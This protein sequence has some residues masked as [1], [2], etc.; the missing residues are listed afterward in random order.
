[1]IIWK[2][3]M[4]TLATTMFVASAGMAI[5]VSPTEN[6]FNYRDTLNNEI[7]PSCNTPVF[8][9]YPNERIDST[10][11]VTLIEK[12]GILPLTK[13]LSVEINIVNPLEKQYNK[14]KDFK[15]YQNLINKMKV[16]TNLKVIGIGN[17]ATFVNDV[18]ANNAY[19]V[20]GIFTYGGK[21]SS[22]TK[23][24]CPVPAYIAL[25]NKKAAASYAR[26]N[27]AKEIKQ[28]KEHIYYRNENDSLQQVVLGLNKK[29]TLA[30]AMKNAWETV[31]S[32]NYRY[33][34]YKHTFYTGA[35]FGQYGAYEIEPFTNIEAL[36]FK[37]T[38]VYKQINEPV[39]PTA[40]KF[41]WYEYTSKAIEQAAPN[42]LPLIVL[43][44]GNMNDNRT[45]SE[46]SG[47]M[48][49]AAR[50]RLMVIEI[51]W[52]GASGKNG[53]HSD[54]F[55]GLNGIETIVYDVLK[56]YPQID[57]SKIYI[58]G[59]SAGSMASAASGIQKSHLY[60][61]IGC[62]SGGIFDKVVYSF[63]FETLCDQAIQKQGTVQTPVF[64]VAGTDDDTI[65]Y[66][67]EENHKENPYINLIHAYQLLNGIEK[68]PLD[69]KYNKHFGMKVQDPYEIK[70]N[71][72]INMQTGFFYKDNIPLIQVTSIEHYGHW[73]FRP[74]AEEMWKFFKHFSRD[75]KTKK[76]IYTK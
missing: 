12:L 37:R 16:I 7:N 26:I 28:E 62:H 54:V 31:L 71:K 1:M 15:A 18:I 32:K 45:Q 65:H 13:G 29:Q 14:E 46:T 10:Q 43:L 47:W 33:S 51:E 74:A 5:N 61:A 34:N 48:E 70:T 36:G 50:E 24:A 3:T 66:P 39:I 27:Q 4:L 19:E 75:P 55:V 20:A 68:S 73:N 17:G 9:V 72:G 64:L 44:H 41:F 56:R 30:D 59:C 25:G 53:P 8:I 42:T 21:M 22:K 49:I 40:G 58:E 35:T 11:A 23:S 57:K 76:L 38:P 6:G 69:F 67:T 52:Q 2:K 63:C 60:A